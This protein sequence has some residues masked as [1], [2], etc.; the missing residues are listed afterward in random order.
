[1]YEYENELFEKTKGIKLVDAKN[2]SYKIF[3]GEDIEKV[4]KI[5]KGIK[6]TLEQGKN[7]D[8]DTLIAIGVK[9]Y[10]DE[11]MFLQVDCFDLVETIEYYC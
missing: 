1:M 3:V 2:G 8:W 11:R 6:H 4:S 7:I 5:V 10:E 9:Y